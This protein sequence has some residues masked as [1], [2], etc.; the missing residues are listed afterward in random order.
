VA[1]ICINIT[2]PLIYWISQL[3]K[4]EKPFPHCWISDCAGHY[5]EF[6]FFRIST[7]SGSALIALGWMTNHFY[8]RSIAKENAFNIAKYHPEISMILGLIGSM[9]LMGST[10]NIDTGKSNGKWHTFCASNF[11]VFT[12]LAQIYNTVIFWIVSQKIQAVNKNNLYLK[13]FVLAL[14][15]IQLII[16]L[17]D[18]MY[19]KE[20]FGIDQNA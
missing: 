11:F 8:L 14:L 19:A 18:G 12:I 7:I 17:Q 5:P 4:H 13:L 20:D 15:A 6:V 16:A 3:Y 2:L 1:V 10:A 9:L